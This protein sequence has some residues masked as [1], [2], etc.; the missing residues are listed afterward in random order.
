MKI[1]KNA[2]TFEVIYKP[3]NVIGTIANA[4]RTCYQSFDKST[5]DND[6]K[7]VKNLITRGHGAMLEFCDMTVRFKNISIGMTRELNRHR[8]A[9]IAELSTR[10][11]DMVDDFEFIFPPNRYDNESLI[12]KGC[13]HVGI[14]S[15]KQVL[16]IFEWLY[17]SLRKLGWVPE[18]ARQFLPIANKTEICFKANL[19]E[20]RHIFTCRCSKFAHWEIRSVMLKLLKWC[21]E[22]IPLIFDDFEFFYENGK[23]Y[24][25]PVLSSFNLANNI[26]DYIKSGKDIVKLFE[27]IP[28][29]SYNKIYEL[30]EDEGKLK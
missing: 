22:N 1:L 17:K 14:G 4:A 8:L 21:K 13:V 9:S 10:Y 6:E 16:N 25:L 15:L 5:E 12:D 20:W 23:E 26:N 19:R 7:L 27:K 24:A 11:V 28:A 3:E 2:E 18:D 30:F 29:E